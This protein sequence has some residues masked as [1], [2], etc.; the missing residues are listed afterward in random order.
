MKS[1]SPV[2]GLA[3]EKCLPD[4]KILKSTNGLILVSVRFITLPTVISTV[5]IHCDSAHWWRIGNLI[6]W[7]IMKREI[8]D[9]KGKRENLFLLRFINF[10]SE[11]ESR[12]KQTALEIFQIFSSSRI[13]ISSTA[14]GSTLLSKHLTFCHPR[15]RLFIRSLNVF[16]RLLFLLRS[17]L[18]ERERANEKRKFSCRKFM[19]KFKDSVYGKRKEITILKLLSYARHTILQVC[20]ENL[21]TSNGT[22]AKAIVRGDK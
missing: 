10:P 13:I 1:R 18:L 19:N 6:A 4:R 8:V 2:H 3:V 9:R 5:E 15:L 7:K 21:L 22:S 12:R 14:S 11:I 20:R 17:H 16:F